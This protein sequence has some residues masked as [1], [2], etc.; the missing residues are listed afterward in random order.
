MWE[1]RF[2]VHLLF[3]ALLL[4]QT[5]AIAH[6]FDHPA[7]AP[8]SVHACATCGHGSGGTLPPVAAELVLRHTA[9]L[10]T[11]R[12]ARSIGSAVTLAYQ[13]RAPPHSFV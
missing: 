2:S 5:L 8:H 1:H 10:P 13:S 7:T 12:V 3:V 9:V 6:A 11:E 4:G